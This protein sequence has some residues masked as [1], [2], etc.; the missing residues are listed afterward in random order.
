M[1]DIVYPNKEH[2]KA[3]E[4]ARR[5]ALTAIGDLSDNLAMLRQR[6]E[7]G[8]EFRIDADSAQ[9]LAEYVRKL[10]GHLAEL[11]TLYDV[12]E[13]HKADLAEGYTPSPGDVIMLPRAPSAWNR[14]HPYKIR[15]VQ[16]GQVSYDAHDPT[17]VEPEEPWYCA[18]LDELRQMGMR[19]ATPEEA[20]GK[21]I[22][23]S[24]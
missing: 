22:P 5:R 23:A 7:S 13:W 14:I 6:L 18:G 1:S 9:G 2:K 17:D 20:N 16:D 3:D 21:E 24:E 10:A 15:S 11:G 4:T 12:R 19:P 8:P